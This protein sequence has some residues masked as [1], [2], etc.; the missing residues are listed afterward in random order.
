MSGLPVS[1]FIVTMDHSLSR[2]LSS[3]VNTPNTSLS[4]RGKTKIRNNFNNAR[5]VIFARSISFVFIRY[6]ADYD[7][8]FS[9]WQAAQ[10]LRGADDIPAYVPVL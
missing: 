8:C 7:I 10:R 6:S 1:F 3:D 5:L 2:V 9:L 4:V